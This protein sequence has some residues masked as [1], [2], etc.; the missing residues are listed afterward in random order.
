[1]K[2]KVQFIFLYLLTLMGCEK[3]P[4]G[5]LEDPRVILISIDGLRG[6]LLTDSIF[7]TPEPSEESTLFALMCNLY[8]HP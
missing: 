2:S 1:M 8:S 6:D 3:G 5:K 7:K 4:V